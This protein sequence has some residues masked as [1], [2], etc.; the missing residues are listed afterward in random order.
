MKKD[1][2]DNLMKSIAT[3]IVNAR[4]FL[5]VLFVIAAIFS[6]FT[7]GKVK[8]NPDI[9]SFLPKNTETRR[10]ID[11]ME[12]EFTTY[13]TA[14]IMIEEIQKDEAKKLA[15]DLGDMPHVLNV[16]FDDT[17]AHYRDGDALISIS[18]DGEPQEEELLNAM[19]G[20]KEKLSGYKVYVS[21]EV[22]DDYNN[23][24]AKEMTGVILIAVI[25]IVT[26]LLL[27]SRS[28][29]E[30]VIFFIIFMFAGV[31]NMGTN[32]VLGTI[33]SITNSVA[34]I[35]QLALA[36]D[37]SIIFSHRYQDEAARCDSDREALIE[38]LSKAIIEI[39][40]SSLTTISGL[41]ALMLMQ[42][43]LGYDLGTVLSK[44]I[45]CSLLSVFLL[46]PGVIS[47]FPK[48]IKR[49]MHKN[50]VPD[51][52][53]W[54]RFLVNAKH[55]FVVVFF[56][57]LPF[58][59]YFSNKTEYA[60]SDSS[61]DQIIYSEKRENEK[62]ITDKFGS[63]T[64][65]A[66]IVPAGDYEKQRRLIRDVQEVDAVS[67]VM[68]IADIDIGGGIMLTDKFKIDDI[69]ATLNVDREQVQKLFEAYRMVH[70]GLFGAS[71]DIEEYEVSL[72]D[73]F[74]FLISTYDAGFVT[75]DD[76]TEN[77]I[78]E[79]GGMFSMAK[80]Q[81]SGKN[82]DRIVMSTYL[83]AEGEES[84]EL[85]SDIRDIAQDIYGDKET[86]VVG[87]ITSASD[88]AD[89]Y[90]GDSIKIS[91]LTILFVFLIL[92]FTFRTVVGAV[93]LVFVIQGSIWI[94]FSFPFLQDFKT[95]FVTNMIVS[96]IQMGATI[97]YAIVI[98][99]RYLSDRKLMEKKEAMVNA[100]AGS[101]ATVI[102]SGSILTAAGFLIAYR[103][104]DVYV[105]HIGLAVGRGA[106][107]SIILVLTVLPQLI[108]V[109][110]RWIFK[111]KEC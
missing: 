43:R 60:F 17:D 22:G 48:A 23:V 95:S 51:V 20:V 45:I 8:I 96:A 21:S 3:G 1:K 54:G 40:S 84:R 76:A 27:T 59:I 53:G 77:M 102:T 63:S 73:L 109:F 88:L 103:V 67:S 91:L 66:V 35:L 32:Y 81:L 34:I 14:N 31:I 101:F 15:E 83:P 9:T 110:D 75:L 16:E 26:V 6:V 71:G 18:F 4:Y 90:T 86:L 100:V 64:S 13:G 46:M 36:I 85:V 82:Y 111:G 57:I 44:G 10:G 39:S 58:A 72:L 11:I 19:S 25:V 89:S 29:F 79:L 52:S 62:H 5:F 28:Y 42:F 80:A 69:S 65:I 30:V 78:E 99:N 24:L 104:S 61:I 93:V 38:A 98:M 55:V 50:L 87:N 108:L 2:R 106:L 33:S 12:E 94:N 70:G 105:G 56:L 68:G 107:I 37:Y 92:L 49:T 7:M 41:V 47:L 97:D 74:D